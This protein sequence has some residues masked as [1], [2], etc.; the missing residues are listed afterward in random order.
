MTIVMQIGDMLQKSYVLVT[1]TYRN[2]R[3]LNFI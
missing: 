1:K 2:V 3:T